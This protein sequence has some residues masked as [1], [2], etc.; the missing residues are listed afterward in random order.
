MIGA[1]EA[2]SAEPILVGDLEGSATSVER[3]DG[4]E[5]F[6]PCGFCLGCSRGDG[7]GGL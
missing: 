3:G 1:S 5:G 6:F 2:I 7:P 4:E